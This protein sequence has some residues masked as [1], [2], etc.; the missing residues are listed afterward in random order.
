MVNFWINT[1]RASVNHW[2]ELST[3][4]IVLTYRWGSNYAGMSIFDQ[5]WY[6]YF[7]MYAMSVLACSDWETWQDLLLVRS[8]NVSSF[9]IMQSQI[10]RPTCDCKLVCYAW[11]NCRWEPTNCAP[12][13]NIRQ[14]D[15][16]ALQLIDDD[17]NNFFALTPLLMRRAQ[18][19]T[20][21]SVCMYVSLPLLLTVNWGTTL[22]TA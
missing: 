5:V 10:T 15:E 17:S 12:S 14:D 21:L 6:L 19:E 8:V 9:C 16:R 13:I 11:L 22:L 7:C 2:L 3:Y 4:V 20:R 1:R 18:V